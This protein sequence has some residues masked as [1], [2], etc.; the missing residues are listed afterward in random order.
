M[1]EFKNVLLY[2]DSYEIQPGQWRAHVFMRRKGD[3]DP[4][5]S[6]VAALGHFDSELA[7]N[8]MALSW[9]RVLVGRATWDNG[10]RPSS[11]IDGQVRPFSGDG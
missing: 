6:A 9:A 2:P 3:R 1:L 4:P 11:A 7:A 10:K 8:A 5:V